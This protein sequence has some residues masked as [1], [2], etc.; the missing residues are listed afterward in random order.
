MALASF[1]SFTVA[2]QRGDGGSVFSDGLLLRV[3]CSLCLGCRSLRVG[4]CLLRLLQLR[5]L[6]GKIALQAVDLP[7]E[8]LAQRLNL[9]FDRWSR[10]CLGLLGCNVLLRRRGLAAGVGIGNNETGCQDCR[11][12]SIQFEVHWASSVLSNQVGFVTAPACTSNAAVFTHS[13]IVPVEAVRCAH[14]QAGVNEE[15]QLANCARCT[16]LPVPNPRLAEFD[17][18]LTNSHVFNRV[19]W[20]LSTIA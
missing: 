17:E 6:V 15:G 1:M 9:F 13:R 8:L 7:L 18:Y 11:G 16:V 20:T 12:S 2:L 4:R 10:R 19:A 3:G 5:I 14:R